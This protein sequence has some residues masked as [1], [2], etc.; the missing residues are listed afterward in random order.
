M[1]SSRCRWCCCCCCCATFSNTIIYREIK[2]VPQNRFYLTPK[3]FSTL[4]RLPYKYEHWIK[5]KYDYL[6]WFRNLVRLTLWRHPN[7]NSRHHMRVCVCSFWG[8]NGRKVFPVQSEGYMCIYFA[9][10]AHAHI[11]VDRKLIHSICFYFT[12]RFMELD[13]KV[14]KHSKISFKLLHSV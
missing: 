1:R 8:K 12:I 3:I 9:S 10:H 5:T 14:F 11:E 13:E 4:M 7:T 2:F 6:I